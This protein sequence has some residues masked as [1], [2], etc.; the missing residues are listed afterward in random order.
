MLEEELWRVTH[1]PEGEGSF[2]RNTFDHTGSKVGQPEQLTMLIYVYYNDKA[3]SNS[4]SPSCTQKPA[5]SWDPSC[6][7][8]ASLEF[9]P[10]DFITLLK[11]TLS[12]PRQYRDETPGSKT[13]HSGGLKKAQSCRVMNYASHSK[14]CIIVPSPAL[15]PFLA[16][17]LTYEYEYFS[18]HC[19]VQTAK[20][21]D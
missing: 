19:F 12:L 1:V 14:I 6:C 2:A 3:V 11:E 13:L 21:W 16:K 7:L 10:A 5:L 4:T 17:Y 9:L 20:P 15:S 18:L 8:E